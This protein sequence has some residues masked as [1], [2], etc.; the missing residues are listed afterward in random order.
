[1]IKLKFL[2]TYPILGILKLIMVGHF[3]FFR[4]ENF[5]SISLPETAHFVYSNGLAIWHGLPDIR[6]VK[7]N[8]G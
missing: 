3:E 7:V 8:Y 4:V 5:Q 1:M 2:R 6:H